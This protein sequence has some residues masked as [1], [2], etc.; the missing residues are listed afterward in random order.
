[1][2]AELGVRGGVWER[3]SVVSADAICTLVG[4]SPLEPGDG[5]S[6][7]LAY[8]ISRKLDCGKRHSLDIST[9]RTPQHRPASHVYE[10]VYMLNLCSASNILVIAY[11][12]NGS[13]CFSD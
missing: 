2:A 8:G 12:V 5:A 3:E 9:R 13:S 7:V 6:P 4:V 1:M 11:G 10:L